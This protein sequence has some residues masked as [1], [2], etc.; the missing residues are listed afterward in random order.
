MKIN[1]QQSAISNTVDFPAHGKINLTLEILGKRADGYHDLRS[2]VLPISLCDTITVSARAD[3]SVTCRTIGDGTDVSELDSLPLEKQLAVK[4]LRAMQRLYGVETGADILIVKRIPIGAGMG[5]GSADAAGVM[6]AFLES[7]NND[8]LQSSITNQQSSISN[9]QSSILSAAAAEI[10]SDVPALLAGGPV[11]MEGRGERITPLPAMNPPLH[12]VIAFPG[13][14]VSTKRIYD[15][16]RL[17]K[18]KAHSPKPPRNHQM[19]NDLEETVFRL[20][21]E[22][23]RLRDTLLASGATAAMLSGS[24]SAVFGLAKSSDHARTIQSNLP[25]KLWSRVVHTT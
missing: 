1:N 6:R 8:S 13:F 23:K 12:L 21:P 7:R 19:Y 3:S 10:G 11:L 24:G 20:Y 2:I 9:H 17:E 16:L 18:G 5:G 4:A 15:E 14:P 22:T 25:S